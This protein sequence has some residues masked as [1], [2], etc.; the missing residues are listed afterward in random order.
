MTKGGRLVFLDP[1][2]SS[3]IQFQASSIL[4]ENG[5]KIQAGSYCDPFGQNGAHLQIG[6][7]GNDPTAQGTTP[8]TSAISCIAEGGNCFPAGT[9]DKYCINDG[10]GFDPDDPCQSSS[11]GAIGD[12]ALFESYGNLPFD[13]PSGAQ[14]P[15]VFFGYK[16]LAVAYGGH[17]EL[18][19]AKG[20]DPADRQ[21]PGAET[22][23]KLPSDP[24]DVTQWAMGSGGGWAR[25]NQDAATG[26]QMLTLDRDVDWATGDQIV[27]AT[28]D[29]HPSHSE[30]L[31]VAMPEGGDPLSVVRLASGLAYG[32]HGTIYQVPG[33]VLSDLQ[34]A[35]PDPTW[36]PPNTEVET[37]AAVGLLSRSITVES[38]GDLASDKMSISP[39]PAAA[40]CGIDSV[41]SN[42]QG[43]ER[44]LLRRP[45]E[46]APGLRQLPGPGRRV[47]EP[48]PGRAS[49]PL[50]GALSPGQ[51]DRLHRRLSQGQLGVELQHPLRDDPRHPRRNPGA[52]CGLPLARP[53][54]LFGRRQ[55]DQQ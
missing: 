18:F 31:Q 35:H 43:R 22:A 42:P 51:V 32:H 19:G 36:T 44:L 21:A 27:V 38:L 53:R 23:P 41:A 26:A 1:G 17:L 8:S 48:G 4:V 40:D 45:C 55:R 20:V 34:D 25:L 37:R 24:G 54:L 49:R 29:W 47:Q 13:N 30:Q 6:L 5:G 46:C 16:A 10:P 50:P 33:S 3:S 28:T 7:W 15:G 52:Q 12:N 9:L 14:L 39:F 2:D 11:G